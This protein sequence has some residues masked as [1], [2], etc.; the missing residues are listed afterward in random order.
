MLCQ[1]ALRSERKELH[2]FGNAR[3]SFQE[4]DA[5]KTYCITHVGKLECGEVGGWPGKCSSSRQ[6]VDPEC[7]IVVAL[8]VPLLSHNLKFVFL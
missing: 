7:I 2:P 1:D 8:I 3:D 6:V 4:D 5:L